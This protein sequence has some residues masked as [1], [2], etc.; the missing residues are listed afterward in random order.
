MNIAALK[1]WAR[2]TGKK[3]L[4]AGLFLSLVFFDF[5]Q[6][7][8]FAQTTTV[9]RPYVLTSPENIS[10]LVDIQALTY[11]GGKWNYKINWRRTLDR[12][13]SIY[14]SPKLNKA[15]PVSG[16]PATT[17]IGRTGN[18]TVLLDAG[19]RYRIEFY[20]EPNGGGRLLLRK[21]FNTLSSEGNTVST[22]QAIGGG[23]TGTA[24]APGQQATTTSPSTE[25]EVLM[26]VGNNLNSYNGMRNAPEPMLVI[27]NPKTEGSQRTFTEG[28]SDSIAWGREVTRP[29]NGFREIWVY[30]TVGRKFIT[31]VGYNS[32]GN[33]CTSGVIAFTRNLQLPPGLVYNQKCQTTGNP[34]QNIDGSITGAPSSAGI[35]LAEFISKRTVGGKTIEGKTRIRFIIMGSNQFSVQASDAT[36][37]QAL[38]SLPIGSRSRI[39]WNQTA[40]RTGVTYF[41]E[42]DIWIAPASGNLGKHPDFV[43]N[44]QLIATYAGSY[45]GCNNSGRGGNDPWEYGCGT[46]NW[47]TGNTLG[48]NLAAGDYIIY[49]TP[50]LPVSDLDRAGTGG[51]RGLLYGT[52]GEIPDPLN[53]GQ[54]ITQT[55]CTGFSWGSARV[56]LTG[57]G[58]NL[59][60]ANP[61]AFLDLADIKGGI[62]YVRKNSNGQILKQGEVGIGR[63]SNTDT[64]GCD[65][66]WTGG[67]DCG[68][69]I[70]ANPGEKLQLGWSAKNSQGQPA[71]HAW[72]SQVFVS[73]PYDQGNEAVVRQ[74]KDCTSVIE[75]GG[76]GP[77]PSQGFM[78]SS[79][80]SKEFTV[81]N[82]LGGKSLYFHYDVW[83]YG[84]ANVGGS[85]NNYSAYQI[86][87]NGVL[88]AGQ[89]SCQLAVK[90]SSLVVVNIGLT[91]SSSGEI[92]SASCRLPSAISGARCE[93]NS[94]GGY[95]VSWNAFDGN[96]LPEV[97]SLKAGE[98]KSEVEAGCV[99][100]SNCIVPNFERRTF[101][102]SSSVVNQPIEVM[103][104]QNGKT[105]WNKLAVSCGLGGQQ[106]TREVV[107]SCQVGS[108]G[109]T[110]TGGNTD[111]FNSPTCVLPPQS[112]MFAAVGPQCTTGVGLKGETT[113]STT[114][115]MATFHDL[116]ING[117]KFDR[118]TFLVDRSQ[119]N[120][121]S[122]CAQSPCLINRNVDLSNPNLDANEPGRQFVDSLSSN[123]TYQ[124]RL[125]YWCGNNYRD[126]VWSCSTDR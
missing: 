101:A 38:T 49:V 57:S 97:I 29:E 16:N 86:D 94:S 81:P 115:Y 30:G 15:A 75:P 13:G 121:A 23:A 87:P 3:I 112:E 124:N 119:S 60:S 20:S 27:V 125:I 19:T 40:G 7:S 44:K 18:T 93:T 63:G 78:N 80:G 54:T 25:N 110:T 31:S 122:G 26:K 82:C 113:L 72:D 69:T 74:V 79:A 43:S 85:A 45:S 2:K 64:A 108:T 111:P 36:T 67:V 123:T 28:P 114:S 11:S 66:N 48:P 17:S 42:I 77:N 33:L 35:Y 102:Q 76:Y 116:R 91:D 52:C 65:G 90:S 12:Q 62:S 71:G 96:S 88:S 32:F 41:D 58:S 50:W 1:A 39:N 106:E 68:I 107:F 117:A 10:L 4:L 61:G 47:L 24:A 98:N 8:V 70:N 83:I 92:T 126:V 120:I 46:F 5:G 6:M 104:T 37:G 105:Y 9:Y 22:S 59:S 89:N 73:G 109:Q 103:G 14:V 34:L 51:V 55:N 100:P 95:K 53:P 118:V 21:F 99:S 84:C 56:T